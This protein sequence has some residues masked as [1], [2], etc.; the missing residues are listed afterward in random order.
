M[1]RVTRRIL[2][3]VAAF[4]IAFSGSGF[5]CEAATSN[6]LTATIT[7]KTA[8]AV[9]TYGRYGYVLMVRIEF[10]EQHKTTGQ[11]Y[12]GKREATVSG[13]AASVSTTRSVDSGYY[14]AEMNAAGFVNGS[15]KAALTG[16]RP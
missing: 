10:S 16:V 15:Q 7:K 3:L 12:T 9:Y 1:G 5:P 2:A 13:N 4:M 14:Y 11:V 6:G 8:K